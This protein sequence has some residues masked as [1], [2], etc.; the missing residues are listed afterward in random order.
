VIYVL[1]ASVLLKWFVEESASLQALTY[2]TR[3]LEGTL[4]AACPDL[5]L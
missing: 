1:D 4:T 2:R 3:L 5:A